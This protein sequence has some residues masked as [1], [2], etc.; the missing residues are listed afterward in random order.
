MLAVSS[1][2][3]EHEPSSACWLEVNRTG[4]NRITQR[5]FPC[6]LAG[7]ISHRA[8][9]QAHQ[10]AEL[11]L[12][13]GLIRSPGASGPTNRL[14]PRTSE[15]RGNLHKAHATPLDLLYRKRYK[16]AAIFY[17]GPSCLCSKIIQ[18]VFVCLQSQSSCLL[19]LLPLDK[20][21]PY[22]FSPF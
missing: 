4:I 12:H 15:L 1:A 22:Q 2:V 18:L 7:T 11:L 21:L 6:H 3:Q 10:F 20:P 17:L 16:R 13:R 9:R 5:C 8:R 14:L 19:F